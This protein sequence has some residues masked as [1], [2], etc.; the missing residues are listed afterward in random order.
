MNELDELLRAINDF[1]HFNGYYPDVYISEAFYE[2]HYGELSRL[3][4]QIRFDF[5][6]SAHP[7]T[8]TSALPPNIV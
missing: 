5:A 2:A 8:L 1:Y 6:D 3:A 7:W 4:R